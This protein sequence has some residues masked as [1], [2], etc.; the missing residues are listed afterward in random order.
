MEEFK[1]T[2]H[3]VLTKRLLEVSHIFSEQYFEDVFEGGL[4]G[5]RARA[6]GIN[7][8]E[9]RV[10]LRSRIPG[11]A[12]PPHVLGAC[13]PSCACSRVIVE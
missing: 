3:R 6:R 8:G 12:A 9:V 5:L 11:S 1:R 4:E 2:V 10:A 7:L 13:S